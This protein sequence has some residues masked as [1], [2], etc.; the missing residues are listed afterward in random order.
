M[1]AYRFEYNKRH[2]VVLIVT[3]ISLLL[4][5]LF[6]GLIHWISI[7]P[8]V[9]HWNIS[10][11][12]HVEYADCEFWIEW[13]SRSEYSLQTSVTRIYVKP[14]EIYDLRTC[15]D[16]VQ[17]ENWTKLSARRKHK[18]L[19]IEVSIM[20]IFT[21]CIFFSAQPCILLLKWIYYNI[22]SILLITELCWVLG[23][24]SDEI[25]RCRKIGENFISILETN[26]R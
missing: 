25:Q 7:R 5:T 22:S 1:K 26:L 20:N 2:A 6:N 10:A 14:N 23:S 3:H 11:K 18:P 8:H 15:L 16:F 19:F 24:S 12:S 21:L 9:L 4:S 13:T 17:H